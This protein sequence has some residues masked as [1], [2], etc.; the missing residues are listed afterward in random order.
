MT[1]KQGIYLT[2]KWQ[3]FTLIYPAL[4]AQPSGHLTIPHLLF[5]S[6]R[7]VFVGRSAR[8]DPFCLSAYMSV[9]FTLIESGQYEVD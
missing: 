9:Q 7:D 3:H 6:V 1:H 4:H 2:F 8:H 5:N